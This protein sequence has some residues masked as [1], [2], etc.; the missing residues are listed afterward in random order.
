AGR[1]VTPWET[2]AL[3]Q[4]RAGGLRPR[5][6]VRRV[7]RGLRS[8][9][10]L[11]LSQVDVDRAIAEG[12][13]PARGRKAGNGVDLR[14]PGQERGCAVDQGRIGVIVRLVAQDAAHCCDNR[15]Q[16]LTWC[17]RRDRTNPGGEHGST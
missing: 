1:N 2:A 12:G 13:H 11:V 17:E 3:L 16:R 10:D 5:A 14:A 7:V 6:W 4:A 8:A 15:A 9:V